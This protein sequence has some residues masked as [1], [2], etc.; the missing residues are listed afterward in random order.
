MPGFCGSALAAS[1]IDQYE[2][3]CR[4]C[5]AIMCGQFTDMFQLCGAG[6]CNGCSGI[7]ARLLCVSCFH[8]EETTRSS[9]YFDWMHDDWDEAV[10]PYTYD[11]E[12]VGGW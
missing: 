8:L 1:D 10:D 9:E 4:D 5:G 12:E 6:C 11:D 3:D 7:L 2:S